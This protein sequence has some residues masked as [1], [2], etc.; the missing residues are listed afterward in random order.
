MRKK[1]MLGLIRLLECRRDE[2]A[3]RLNVL[4][5]PHTATRLIKHDV[6]M[7]NDDGSWT[8]RYYKSYRE[9]CDKCGKCIGKLTEREC[10]ELKLKRANKR[11]TSERESL[12]TKLGELEDA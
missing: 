2:H 1:T 3:D 9:I 12:E 5:C 11:F 7:Y 6:P 4:E 8:G 10:L